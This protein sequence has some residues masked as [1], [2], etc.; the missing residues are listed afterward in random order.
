VLLRWL[1]A[2]HRD[3]LR[4]IR[5]CLATYGDVVQLPFRAP[6]LILNDP[7]DIQHVLVQNQR[8]YHKAGA[9]KIGHALFGQG[10]L[11]SE[12]ELHLRQR[13]VMQPMFHRERVAAF[14]RVMVETTERATRGWTE[15]AV[16]D[17]AQEM[18]QLTLAIIGKVLFGVDLSRE[19]GELHRRFTLAQRHIERRLRSPIRTGGRFFP[20][21]MRFQRAMRRLDELVLELLA[22]ARRAPARRDD[23][24]T[25][26]LEARFEDGGRMSDRQIRDEVVTML[27]AG[28]ETVANALAWTWYLLAQHPAVEERLVEELVRVLGDRSATAADLER[29]GFCRMTFAETLRLY[30]TAWHIGRKALAEDRLPSGHVVPARAEIVIYLHALHRDPRFFAA[31][32][33]FDPRNFCE[34]AC[35]ARP[36]FAYL[37]FGAGTRTCIGEPLARAEAVALIATIARAWRLRLVPGQRIVPEPLITL[38]PKGGIRM[39]L[40]RRR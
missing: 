2:I 36:R 31:P 19:A 17:V 7:G 26:L 13:R 38:R 10:L 39:R 11:S 15:G 40:H 35:R 32:D 33:E 21:S 16:V 6:L 23:L 24:L 12:D 1:P 29:L 37:P 25:L 5:H 9:L 28:H 3:P 14:V 18:A 22:E 34:A 4:A 27:L 20:G 30:P 8:N